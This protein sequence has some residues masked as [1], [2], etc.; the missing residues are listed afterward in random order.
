MDPQA[1]TARSG[2]TSNTRCDPRQTSTKSQ[3]WC[4]SSSSKALSRAAESSAQGVTSKRGTEP[5]D[6]TQ[7][8][9]N[10]CMGATHSLQAGPRTFDG[11]GRGAQIDFRDLLQKNIGLYVAI[12]QGRESRFETHL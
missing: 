4:M 1:A 8:K 6:S 12:H 3:R 10:T 9:V 2:L 5:S 7:K 11:G